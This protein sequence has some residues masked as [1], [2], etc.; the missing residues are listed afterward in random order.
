M[1]EEKNT[2]PL[3]NLDEDTQKKIQELQFL[4]QNFQQFLAQKNAFS[5][6]LN[7]TDYVIKEVEKTSGEVSRIVGNSV[8]IKSTKEE[9]LKDM[10]K[11][12]ELI[13]KRMEELDKQE[14]SFSERIEK[15]REEVM[16]KI[17]G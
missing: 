2:N 16:K 10:K 13:E 8:V 15:L 9:I 14:K 11:K 17:Q 4:E 5:M 7:E 6:E 1:A 12:K 3:G